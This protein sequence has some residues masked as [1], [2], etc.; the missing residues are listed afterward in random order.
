MHALRPR[1]PFGRLTRAALLLLVASWACGGSTESKSTPTPTTPTPVTPKAARVVVVTSPA[2]KGA[3]GSVAGDFV[4]RVEDAAGAG[5]SGVLVTFTGQTSTYGYRFSPS[6]TVRS[7]STGIARV[8]V[9]FKIDPGVD[10]LVATAEGVATPA[11]VDVTVTTGPVMAVRATPD[12]IRLLAAGDSATFQ[13]RVDDS[14]LN[15]ITDATLSFQLSD[16][17]LFSV[18]PPATYNGTGTV[19]ALK[20]GSGTI[21]IA[22]GGKSATLGV[23]IK[24]L[25]VDCGG[26]APTL[27]VGATPVTVT[28]SVACIAAVSGG[29]TYALV[30]FNAAPDGATSVGTTVTGTNVELDRV[31]RNRMATRSSLAR[32]RPSMARVP[33]L[34]RRASGPK[35]D[36]RFHD[37]LMARG[38]ALRP[39]IGPARAARRL[40]RP[41]AVGRI[42]GPSYALSGTAPS[43][44]A[45]DSLVALNVSTDA[46]TT[47]D[48]RTFRVEAVGTK[49]IVLADTANPTGGFT[50][51]DYQ[52]FAARFDTLVYPLDV[53]NFDAPTDIDNNG[54]VAILFTRAVNE[55]TP[56]NANAFVGGFFYARDLFPRTQSSTFPVCATSN[57]G[58]MFYMMV[59]DPAGVVNGN[60]FGLGFVDTLTTSIL[61]HEFQH[62]INAGRRMYVNTAA[63]D[64]EETWLD[65]GLSHEAEELLFFRES[66]YAPRMRLMSQSILDSRA[67]FDPFVSDEAGNFAN[68]FYFLLDPAHHSP[69]DAND[70]IETR[71]ATW[72]FLRWAMDTSFPSDAGA[73]QRFANSTTTG[74][75]TLSFGFQRDP[76]TLLKDFAVTNM[77]GWGGHPS[78]NF[79]NMYV[80]VFDQYDYPLTYRGLQAGA[81]DSVSVMGGSA[82]YYKFYVS[83]GVQ[84]LLR[85]GSPD[86]DLRYVLTR[87]GP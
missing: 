40:A 12:S 1:S 82:A 55:L 24:P 8:T 53:G 17:T 26:A 30:V 19:R 70:G 57:E 36:L 63:T 29:A 11:M 79:G 84:G 10:R 35:P 5:V 45:V 46:C 83:P 49:A 51:A 52:R 75:G 76:M 9:T 32:V 77:T 61:A 20:A 22:T 4:V 38:R 56:A 72:A 58:E 7:D 68:F 86:P 39:L 31:S 71:G 34:D 44:P 85:F 41:G 78:W 74:L 87:T 60:Q 67:H 66:G 69:I 16:S 21:S 25:Q 6:D 59:P 2:T 47:A 42:R 3:V 37:R 64:F 27:S 62:L 80:Y 81:P 73:W 13:V 43:V 15:P 65:E 14:F 48:T 50:R 23:K 54:H 28:D 33:T 18:T